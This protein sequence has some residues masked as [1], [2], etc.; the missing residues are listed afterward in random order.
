MVPTLLKKQ[1]KQAEQQVCMSCVMVDDD[2]SVIFSGL[3]TIN[4]ASIHQSWFKLENCI[5][6]HWSGLKKK[7]IESLN[8]RLSLRL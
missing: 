2:F 8:L 4:S 1:K 3:W 6:S 5:F 7:T